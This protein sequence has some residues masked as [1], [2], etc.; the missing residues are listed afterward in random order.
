MTDQHMPLWS[1]QRIAHELGVIN[2]AMLDYA[3]SF[4]VGLEIA[5][6]LSRK[7]R[8]DYEAD[9]SISQAGCK[10][11]SDAL[12]T[13]LQRYEILEA[14]LTTANQRAAEYL[15]AAEEFERIAAEALERMKAAEAQAQEWKTG[16]H[17]CNTERNNE[18][19]KWI[20]AE[21]RIAELEQ[22]VADCRV[23]I[24]EDCKLLDSWVEKGKTYLARIAELE[25][26]LQF[27]AQYKGI[28]GRSCPLCRYENG[29]YLGP[30]QMHADMDRMSDTIAELE[31]Q[32]AERWVPMEAY[33]EIYID[34]EDGQKY[35]IGIDGD[36]NLFV[37]RRDARDAIVVLPSDEYRLC[38][39]VQAGEGE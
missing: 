29:V 13:Q 32:L 1:D 16:Y 30:C 5:L 7:I 4:N 15:K 10:A 8:D 18:R 28:E 3:S 21:A 23:T 39:Q 14:Q 33:C 2:D 25:E 36:D 31:A 11:F 24:R 27:A 37:R 17:I 9:L 26:T 35:T 6:K 22:E 34:G 19:E 12:T 20:A 38:R